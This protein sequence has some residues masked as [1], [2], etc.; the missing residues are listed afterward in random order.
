MRVLI[1]PDCFGGTLT[2]PEAAEAIAAG[3]RSG[4]PD[5]EL[6]LC[7]LADGGPGFVDVLY[8][9]LG[10]H[11]RH[12]SVPG[13]LGAS[14]DAVWLEH[15]GTAYIE[16]AQACGLTLVPKEERD[17][18]AANTVGVGELIMHALDSGVHTI[19][20]GLGGSG[21]TDGGA[22]MFRALG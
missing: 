17:A 9:A 21:S 10:G 5:D 13:P 4:A 20:V 6:T 11:L 14:T 15:D 2:A 3:W 8:S 16:C 1:A 7:P 22:G 19:V 12:R 18:L